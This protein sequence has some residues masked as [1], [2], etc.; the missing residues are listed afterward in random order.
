MIYWEQSL[1]LDPTDIKMIILSKYFNKFL[2]LFLLLRATPATYGGSQAR[3]LIGPTA[4][5]L[6]HSPSN[7]TS[8][9]HLQPT[10]Q[11][12]ATWDP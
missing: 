1:L 2:F 11:L 12:T 9:P 8:E 7:A 10:P 5:S 4:A 3:S 6:H